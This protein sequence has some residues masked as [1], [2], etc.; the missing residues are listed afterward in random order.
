MNIKKT[1]LIISSLTLA[2]DIYARVY[3]ESMKIRREMGQSKSLLFMT[4]TKVTEFVR[5]S[6]KK[7]NQ[8]EDKS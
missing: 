5:R 7:L 2:A 3:T 1:I 8:N 4:L 6:N